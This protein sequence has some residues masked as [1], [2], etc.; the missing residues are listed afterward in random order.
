MERVI[1]ELTV[2]KRASN[3]ALIDQLPQK[4]GLSLVDF[5][6]WKY[7]SHTL[8]VGGN[9]TLH[10]I[11]PAFRE[12]AQLP[13]SP[14]SVEDLPDG[15]L[16]WSITKGLETSASCQMACTMK[17]IQV[18]N[19]KQSRYFDLKFEPFDWNG[20][21][22]VEVEIL[23]YTDCRTE[24]PAL[25]RQHLA[26][27]KIDELLSE[28]SFLDTFVQGAAHDLKG[29]LVVIKSY[30]D[31]IRRFEQKAKKEEA[32]EIMKTAAIRLENTLK[33]LEELINFRSGKSQK[34]Q[35]I[36]FETLFRN[37]RFQ[38]EVEILK[39][40][41]HFEYSFEQTPTIHYI[42]PY[43][44]S[45][46]YNLLSNAIKYARPEV[47]LSIKVHTEQQD[48]TVVLVIR[49]NGIG[50]DLQQYGHLLFEP[51]QRLCTEREGTGLG[52]SL[53][54]KMVRRNGGRIEVESQLGQGTCFR[55]YLKSYS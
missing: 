22:Y 31:L 54:N 21:A 12:L 39:A 49:D 29:P 37:A 36:E 43:L 27:M 45:I 46:M 55:I 25:A 2:L 44:N 4:D 30:V 50:M 11:G 17:Q 19:K 48:D 24:P 42:K 5:M 13:D 7:A 18:G 51:F 23:A 9:S 41:P 1:P 8:L 34:I 53:V 32:L 35:A 16:K 15:L 6:A 10:F 28:K 47:P 38:L 3:K 40:K 26:L 52:L 20:Q 14:R 33:G